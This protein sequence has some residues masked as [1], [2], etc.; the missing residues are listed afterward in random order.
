MFI[1]MAYSLRC[2]VCICNVSTTIQCLYMQRGRYVPMFT[3]VAWSLRPNVYM[4]IV[5]P[6]IQC[7]CICIVSALIQC[8]YMQH[9]RYD[10]MFICV[11]CAYDQMFIYVACPVPSNIYIYSVLATIQY[12]YMQRVP[13]DPMF[14]YVSCPLRPNVYTCIV[15]LTIQCLYLQSFRYNSMFIS[16]GVRCYPMF[17]SVAFPLL[18]VACSLR[19]KVYICSDRSRSLVKIIYQWFQQTTALTNESRS[20]GTYNVSSMD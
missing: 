12:L 11:A 1:S 8:L 7:L 18:F 4:C 9:V 6:T 20:K 13:Y 16:V 17:I 2:I 15:F 3:Y 14:I 5:S 10:L 19:S